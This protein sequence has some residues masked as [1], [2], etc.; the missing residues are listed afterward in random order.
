MIDD[1]KIQLTSLFQ[2]NQ[3]PI[4]IEVIHDNFV[5]FISILTKQKKIAEKTL[6]ITTQSKDDP[7]KY[8]HDS[9]CILVDV[10]I[11]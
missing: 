5:I 7:I 10:C 1:S 3:L 9:N 11:T 4:P 6:Y 2:S 8:I